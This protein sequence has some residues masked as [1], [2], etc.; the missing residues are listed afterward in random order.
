[1]DADDQPRTPERPP[2]VAVLGGTGFVGGRLSETLEKAGIDVVR[3]AR[4]AP[5]GDDPPSVRT[6]DLSRASSAGA[7]T[8]LLDG[9]RIDAVVNAA[10]GMWGLTDEEMV[11]ANVDLVDNVLAAIAA[12]GRPAR[13]VHLGT[14][15]EYGLAP[16]GRS[17]DER[18]PARPVT[19]YARLK[20][21]C[22]EAV[23]AAARQGTVD[24]VVLRAGNITGAGQ[25]RVSLLGIVAGQLWDAHCAG[26]P[27]VIRM[28]SLSSLR[29]FVTLADA[30]SAIVTAVTIPVLPDLVFNVGTGRATSARQ[31]VESLVEVSGVPAELVETEPAGAEPTWQQ[32]CVERARVQLGWLPRQDMVD[33]LKEL[34]AHHTEAGATEPPPKAPG[35]A[36]AGS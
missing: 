34:W 3:V 19:T 25:P 17:L 33:G 29:D 9:A 5:D 7:L 36:P 30:V 4:R 1:M 14:V 20:L 24:A 26:R 12:M 21:R 35:P 6:I 27:A 8:E 2:R 10:G 18:D 22:A 16:I 23:V 32:M 31:M 28:K 13:L 15:H 11:A